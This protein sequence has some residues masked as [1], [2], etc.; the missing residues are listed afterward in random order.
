MV[1]YR[2]YSSNTIQHALRDHDLCVIPVTE[3]PFTICK[4]INRPAL[5]LQ[6]GVPVIADVI[7]AY[8]EL[9]AYIGVGDWV[10]NIDLFLSHRPAWHVRTQMGARYLRTT[11]TP[12]RVIDQWARILSPF[13]TKPA[14]P[15][16][17]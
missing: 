17:A 9:R 13:V 11:Y 8:E 15:H 16:A 6:L 14:A 7:P 12:Q 1:R 10:R 4:T 2:E 5:A 3:N